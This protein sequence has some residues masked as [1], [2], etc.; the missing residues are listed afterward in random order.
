MSGPPLPYLRLSPDERYVIIEPGVESDFYKLDNPVHDDTSTTVIVLDDNNAFA[1]RSLPTGLGDVSGP[2]SSTDDALARFNG[3]SGKSIQNSTVTLDD[4]GNLAGVGTINGKLLP[5]GDFGNVNGPPGATN[6]ALSRFDGTTGRL[7]Q[8]SVTTLD[9]AGNLAGIGT[10]NGK[11]LPA[12]GNF[13]NVTGPAVATDNALA[14]YDGTSG[15]FVQ[16]GSAVLDDSGNLTGVLSIDGKLVAD[17]GD[18]TGPA[19]ATDNAIARYDTTTGKLIQNSTVRLD[20]IG[21]LLGV[22]T[23]N[24]KALPAG[25]FGD[26]TGPA[27]ATDNAVARYDTTTGKLIQNSVVL[28]DDL[29]NL[30]GVGTIDGKTV[31]TGNFGNVNGPASATDNAIARYDTTTGKLIQNS[32][33]LVDDLGNLTGVGTIDGKALPAGSFGDVVGPAGATDNA[34]AR[35]DTTTGKLIQNSTVLVDDLGNLTG[36][37]TINGS[38]FSG[39]NT[40]DVTLAAFGAAPNANAASLAGQVL[41]LQPADASF[42]GGVS[43]TTQSFAGLKTFTSQAAVPNGTLAL[44]GLNFSS[45]T[46][47]GLF[48]DEGGAASNSLNLVSGAAPRYVTYKQKTGLSNGVNNLLFTLGGLN[49]WPYA[50]ANLHFTIEVADGGGNRQVSAGLVAIAVYNF[51]GAIAG[52]CTDYATNTGN[53]GSFTFSFQVLPNP[54]SATISLVPN[55]SFTPTTYQISYSVIMVADPNITIQYF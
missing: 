17:L 36:V 23:I 32:T 43:T 20:D 10:I 42:P 5:V 24:G 13:G 6:N 16:D 31:P 9:G 25:N 3:T 54:T 19:G 29:G 26:V 49:I 2:A 50:N 44:P 22:N 14:R 27:G 35:Y 7:I 12:A 41:T 53:A 39:T 45:H 33:V 48:Y 21:N 47:D 4:A 55:T 37:G 15:Q 46:S 30:T 52:T 38:T 8:N 51:S 40:G 11:L 28:I 1:V 18:V 34:I